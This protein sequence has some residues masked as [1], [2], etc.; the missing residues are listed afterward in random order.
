MFCTFPAERHCVAGLF[1]CASSTSA[2][3]RCSIH[4]NLCDGKEDCPDESDEAE[5]LCMNRH[6]M[7]HQ[8]QCASGECIFRW[9]ACDGYYNCNDRSDELPLNTECSKYHSHTHQHTSDWGNV[10]FSLSLCVFLF[11]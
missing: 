4:Y 3:P 7:P 1:Q 5:E 11:P 9:R 8:F 6:C 10:S 2:V